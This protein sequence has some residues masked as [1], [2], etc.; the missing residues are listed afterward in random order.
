MYVIGFAGKKESGKTTS[1]RFLKNSIEGAEGSKPAVVAFADPLKQIVGFLFDLSEWQLHT[2]E[3]KETI[4]NRYGQTPRQILQTVGT[5][6]FRKAYPDIWIM[7]MKRRLKDLESAGVKYV[8]ID[9]IRF[10][11]ERKVVD[12]FNGTTVELIRGESND[13]H[14][15]EN[16]TL[17]CD[18]VIYNQGSLEDL[19]RKIGEI[20][21][22]HY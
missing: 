18:Y 9:D 14:E 16:E 22:E 12:I 5:D 4:D 19:Y 3:G 2:T 11:N 15:S 10:E 17:N 1:A 21:I 7:H 6:L 13:T 20:F 8:I